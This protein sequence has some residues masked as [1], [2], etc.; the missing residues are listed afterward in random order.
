[1]RGASSRRTVAGPPRLAKFDNLPSPDLP[2]CHGIEARPGIRGQRHHALLHDRGGEGVH[3]RP[4]GK[5]ET[6]VGEVSLAAVNHGPRSSSADEMRA[7]KLTSMPASLGN[8]HDRLWQDVCTL[9]VRWIEFRTLFG[10]SPETIELLNKAAADY[11][12]N[13]QRHQW[14]AVLLHIARLSDP[15][16]TGKKGNLTLLRLSESVPDQDIKDRLNSLEKNLKAKCQFARDWR[17]RHIA[18]KE[19]IGDAPPQPLASASRAQVE[20][21]LEII[22]AMMNV[23]ELRYEGSNTGFEHIHMGHGSVRALLDVLKLGVV[24][25]DAEIEKLRVFGHTPR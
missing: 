25:R 6:E 7:K 11:F 14:E 18:H 12:G 9:Q 10:S 1:M 22:R 24:A 13:Q 4:E 16:M 5:T 19:L 8:L 2:D 17:N 15:P 21:V 20:E 23:V 3:D